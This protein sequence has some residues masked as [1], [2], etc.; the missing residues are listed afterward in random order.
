MFDGPI[1]ALCVKYIEKKLAEIGK[2]P[3]D[4]TLK[5]MDAFWED[6]KKEIQ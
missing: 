1:K 4:S 5:E 6:S 2:S 3:A